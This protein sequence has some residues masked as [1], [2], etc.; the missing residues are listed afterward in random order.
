MTLKDD[1]CTVLRTRGQISC[2]FAGASDERQQLRLVLG[3]QV[4]PAKF[5]SA[6]A[7][8]LPNPL[9][10]DDTDD[11]F[12]WQPARIV[13]SGASFIEY[14]FDVDSKAMRK[15]EAASVVV[16]V[17]GIQSPVRAFGA[18]DSIVAVGALRVLVG[19]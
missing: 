15:M 19:Y 10:Q 4:L 11:W 13:D 16:P 14:S 12:V 17:L 1:D 9:V 5:A 2:I 7:D 6:T 8:N 18:G 3:F